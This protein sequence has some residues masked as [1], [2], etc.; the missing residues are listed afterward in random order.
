MCELTPVVFIVC[1]GT[2]LIFNLFSLVFN[3]IVVIINL[4]DCF[5]INVKKIINREYLSKKPKKLIFVFNVN[6]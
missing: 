2:I 4:I 5:S 6:R 3:Q 1:G